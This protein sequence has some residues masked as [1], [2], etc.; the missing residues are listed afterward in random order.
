MSLPADGR[1]L[2]F[3]VYLELSLDAVALGQVGQGKASQTLS[4]EDFS[5]FLLDSLV[6]G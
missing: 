4:S 1:L 6:I 5:L 3:W 2:S